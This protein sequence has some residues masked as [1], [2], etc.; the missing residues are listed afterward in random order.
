ML[1][2]STSPD[3]SPAS[4]YET[5]ST[6]PQECVNAVCDVPL[7]APRP[8]PCIPPSLFQFDFLPNEKDDDSSRIPHSQF[9]RSREHGFGMRKRRRSPSPPPVIFARPM[10]HV[11]RSVIPLHVAPQPMHDAKRRKAFVMP[12][13][14]TRAHYPQVRHVDVPFAQ[15]PHAPHAERFIMPGAGSDYRTTVGWV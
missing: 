8:L 14:E 7:L 2:D 1:L 12:A 10:P 9:P 5:C 4:L 13:V 11:A 6:P 15:A 3:Q